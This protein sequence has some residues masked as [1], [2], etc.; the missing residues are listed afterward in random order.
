MRGRL[1]HDSTARSF[2]ASFESPAEDAHEL[3]SCMVMSSYVEVLRRGSAVHN[4]AGGRLSKLRTL[5]FP[6]ADLADERRSGINLRREVARWFPSARWAVPL[7]RAALRESVRADRRAFLATLGAGAGG[8][9]FAPACGEDAGSIG[10]LF[11]AIEVAAT[12]YAA[13]TGSGGTAMFSN[14]SQSRERAAL[15]TA[16]MLAGSS[17]VQDEAES[18]VDVPAKEE[19]YMFTYEG[20]ISS[21]L[22]EHVISGTSVGI[23]LLTGVFRFL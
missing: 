15:L 13:G 21:I 3:S 20:L 17:E 11:Q 12:A 2:N 8:I 6:L 10:V 4:D 18:L 16:L 23:T 5:S 19:E 9:V 7:E 22:G 1:R 14:G